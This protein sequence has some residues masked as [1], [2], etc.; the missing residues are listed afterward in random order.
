MEVVLD[1]VGGPLRIEELFELA[2]AFSQDKIASL[3]ALEQAQGK[4]QVFARLF[5]ALAFQEVF[6]LWAS[7]HLTSVALE[8]EFDSHVEGSWVMLPD[9]SQGA[10]V[11]NVLDEERGERWRT[12]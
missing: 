2:G 5:E 6:T 11:G 10:R 1:D 3:N 12:L 7:R 9:R 8:R 4:L